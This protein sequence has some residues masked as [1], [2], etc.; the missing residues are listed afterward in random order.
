MKDTLQTIST[1]YGIPIYE[2]ICEFLKYNIQY[3]PFHFLNKHSEFL[4]FSK[5]II[6]SSA[7]EY[8]INYFIYNI[9]TFLEVNNY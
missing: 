5:E 1:V 8:T 4:S 2:F 9:T 7:N 6:H 3:D